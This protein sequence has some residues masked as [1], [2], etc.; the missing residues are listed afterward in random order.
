MSK[1]KDSRKTL[2]LTHATDLIKKAQKH[3]S[4]MSEQKLNEKD[5]FIIDNERRFFR[6]KK[7]KPHKYLLLNICEE[8]QTG[9]LL[10]T[11]SLSFIADILNAQKALL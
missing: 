10:A 2:E 5:F 6:A 3:D 9:N 11:N 8:S 4:I 7:R 1:Y